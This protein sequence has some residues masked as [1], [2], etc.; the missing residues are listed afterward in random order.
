MGFCRAS[1]REVVGDDSLVGVPPG[2]ATV[3]GEPDADGRD[4]DEELRRVARPG[5]DG[6]EAEAAVAGVPVGARGVVPQAAVQR[7]REAAVAALEQRA[8]VATGVEQAVSLA[9]RDHPDPLER[10]LVALGEGRPLR[11]LPL[12]RRVV[13]DPD[14]RAVEPGRDRGE[15]APG[16]RV[17][18]R[19]LDA[20]ARERARGDLEPVARVP[21]EPEEALLRADQEL[22]HSWCS[23]RCCCRVPGPHGRAEPRRMAR[24]RWC[25]GMRVK[26][27]TGQGSHRSGSS[28]AR[29]GA[30]SLP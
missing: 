22:G 7:P 15:V 10:L 13:G 9:G 25:H 8:G 11:L 16:A 3:V 19:V 18:H 30:P 26:T 17:A 28:G 6:V 1:P 29:E 2:L 21:F 23:F 20:L 12:S 4:R 14:L 24:R 5:R 27:A